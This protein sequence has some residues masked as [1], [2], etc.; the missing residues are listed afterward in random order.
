MDL[1]NRFVNR[2]DFDS[3]E[4]FKQNFKINVPEDFNFG[5]DVVDVYA[6]E[7]P[8]QEALI[9]CDDD[10]N[11]KHFTFK[12][13]SE[14]SNRVANM[15]KDLGI[16]KGDRVLMML[17]QR[18]EVWFTMVGLHKLG[19]LVIPA[20]FQLLY[21]D[22][23]YRCNAADVK[24]IV[25]A[26]DPQIIEHVNKARP[27]CKT[28]QYCSVIGEAPEGWRSLTDDI[29]N[30]SPVFE[31]PTGDEATHA[32]DPMLIYFSS[33]T[34]GEP[35]MILHDYTLPLGHIVTAKYW[36]QVYDGCRH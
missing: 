24:M 36:Q 23:V 35:K 14:K 27:D 32:Y 25:C 20:T 9:W 29:D 11:E 17:R 34:T 19:A 21:H 12:D 18:P 13:I 16:K 15:F 28:V 33:G 22:I 7:V 5:F 8:D 2:I 30:A 6:K 10:G 26:D 3:Y 4:D 31:R 1:L